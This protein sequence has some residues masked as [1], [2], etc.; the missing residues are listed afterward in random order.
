MTDPDATHEAA[1]APADSGLGYYAPPSQGLGERDIARPYEYVSASAMTSSASSPDH[2]GAPTAY[3]GPSYPAPAYAAATGFPPVALPGA[4]APPPRDQRPKGVAATGLVL[5]IIGVVLALVPATAG[6]AVVVMLVA[7]VV[8]IVALA[9]ANRGGKG[10]AGTALAL[11][12]L[13]GLV[14]LVVAVLQ[15]FGAFAPRGGYDASESYGEYEQYEEP[16]D[17]G[18]AAPGTDGIPAD[19][20]VLAAPVPLTVAETA[21]GP[22]TSGLGTWFVVILDNPNAD[23]VFTDAE[24]RV[25]ALDAAGAEITTAS[26]YVT[27]LQ[28][29]SAVVLRGVATGARTVTTVEVTVPAAAAATVSPA[30]ETGS[31][32]VTDVQQFTDSGG[33]E[34]TGS[35][36]GRFAGDQWYARTAVVARDAGGRIVDGQVAYLDRVPADGTPSAFVAWFTPP[37]AGEVTLETYPAP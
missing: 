12:V 35:V 33:T 28:G 7:F 2:A 6:F 31:F 27:A 1:A 16:V 34:V 25:R 15:A 36:V 32:T 14:A 37:L 17:R 4:P 30:D 13:G 22:E 18:V 10:M 19:G 29:R 8:S 23:H 5:A 24:I 26:D 21:F 20:A 9:S 3:D 11:S